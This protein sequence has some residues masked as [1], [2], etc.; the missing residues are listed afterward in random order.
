MGCRVYNL[1]WSDPETGRF[2]E[3]RLVVYIVRATAE[4]SADRIANRVHGHLLS[5]R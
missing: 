1:R 3:S 4:Q 5:G 2:V